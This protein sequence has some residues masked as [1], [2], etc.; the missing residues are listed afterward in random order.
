M[1]SP[2]VLDKERRRFYDGGLPADDSGAG[3]EPADPSKDI[4]VVLD[5]QLESLGDEAEA[6]EDG[7]EKKAETSQE[8]EVS[9]SE[10]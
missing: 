6:S 1:V 8:K 10:Q 7:I 2:V 3:G 9:K 5:R 4:L